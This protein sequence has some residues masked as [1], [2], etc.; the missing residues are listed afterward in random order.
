MSIYRNIIANWGN[1]GTLQRFG[2]KN[3][4]ILF[5]NRLFYVWKWYQAC[6]LE[7]CSDA[8]TQWILEKSSEAFYR[9]EVTLNLPGSHYDRQYNII[10]ILYRNKK[11][12]DIT[13]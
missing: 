5:F 13:F 8:V 6:Y 12:K 9:S 2:T 4:T 1:K 10:N 7:T 3:Q 11:R